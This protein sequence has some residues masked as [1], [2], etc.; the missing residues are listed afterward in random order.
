MRAVASR[1]SRGF[2]SQSVS[3]DESFQFSGRQ[4]MKL[5]LKIAMVG[6]ALAATSAFATTIAP[7]TGNGELV[8]Y[9]RDTVTNVTYA[10]GLGLQIDGVATRATIAA[11]T[12]YTYPTGGTIAYSLPNTSLDANW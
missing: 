8:L 4:D 5:M 7:Q 3:D 12:T 1:W 9:A 2:G 10:K 11:D 6:S